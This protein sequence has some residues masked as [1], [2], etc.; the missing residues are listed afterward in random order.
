MLKRK[1]FLKLIKQVK[2]KGTKSVRYK[3]L[4][5]DECRIIFLS[6]FNV[7]C[8]GNKKVCILNPIRV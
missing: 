7:E 4:A 5:V 1:D 8:D 2:K 6:G 3:D